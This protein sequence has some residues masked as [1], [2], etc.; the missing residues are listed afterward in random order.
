[1]KLLEQVAQVNPQ[2]LTNRADLAH[3]YNM[4]GDA[5]LATG[6]RPGAVRSFRQALDLAESMLNVG[7]AF[8]ST[9]LVSVC[10]KLGQEAAGR[11]EREVAL[12]YARRAL[13]VTDPASKYAKSRP[14]ILQ[15]TMTPRGLAAMGLVYREL[16]RSGDAE[17]G[18]QAVAWLEKSIA[19][20]R[21]VASDPSFAPPRR[22][23]LEQVELALSELQHRRVR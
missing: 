13:E 9:T 11:G 10:L 2:N 12:T 17:D 7:Q 16:A 5:L 23:E 19:A 15:R 6:D 22:R 21:E 4:L 20:W 3:G 18:R 1:V 8:A 14:E